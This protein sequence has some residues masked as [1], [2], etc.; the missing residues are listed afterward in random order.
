[1]NLALRSGLALLILLMAGPLGLAAEPAGWIRRQAGDVSVVRIGV[2]VPPA[3]GVEVFQRDLLT[4]AVGGR[5]EVGFVDGTVI[6]LAESSVVSIDSWHFDPDDHDSSLFLR[7]KAGS[8]MVVAARMAK[9]TGQQLWLRTP[10]ATVGVRGTQF[11]TGPLD[12]RFGVLLLAGEVSVENTS[13]R[14]ELSQPGT[15]VF[16]A[17]PEG[18]VPS[19]L[20]E[21]ADAWIGPGAPPARGGPLSEPEIWNAE[22]VGHVLDAVSF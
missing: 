9:L 1:M 6:I 13:G 16:I 19:E 18:V 15:G 22:R 12:G 14:V 5:L 3:A 8:I 21:P 2:E 17:P 11:W 10:V 4:T 20:A 7:L